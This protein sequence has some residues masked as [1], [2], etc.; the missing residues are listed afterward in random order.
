MDLLD[1]LLL[2]RASLDRAA[3]ARGDATRLAQALAD[4]G[5]SV[6]SVSGG[7]IAAVV[8]G[9]VCVLATTPV[10]SV[11]PRHEL[12]LLGIDDEGRATFALHLPDTPTATLPPLARWANLREIGDRL[13][14]A[15]AG[16]AVTAVALD[17]WRASTAR[18]P[19][20]GTG[21]AIAQAGWAM[22]CA[23]CGI[24]HFPRT[25]PA[26][27]TLVRDDDDR[28]LLGRHVQW[29][30]GWMS[31]FAGFVEA[32]ESAEAAVHREVLEEAGVHLHRLT[33]L[34]SQPWPFP[35]SLM[36]G[37]HAWTHD[38]RSVPDPE[39]IA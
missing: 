27:I 18:C 33:Y 4:P 30:P 19:R 32:G 12:S 37:Y 25:D 39:E 23:P 5:S 3:Q 8:D 29:K 20:C 15:Q 17:H 9:S 10:T 31:T 35:R 38:E 22:H 1:G 36:L 6:V 26:V 28:A 11:D 24:D 2:S 21:L 7:A 13:D 34:G 14:D 16:I